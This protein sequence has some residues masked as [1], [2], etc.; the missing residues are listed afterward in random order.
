MTD[1]IETQEIETTQPIAEAAAPAAEAAPSQDLLQ[2]AETEA[3]TPAAEFIIPDA[4]KEAKCLQD[5]KSQDDLFKSFVNSQDLI[6]KKVADMSAEDLSKY[7][8][9]LGRP[10]TA[11]AYKIE[12][13]DL[14]EGTDLDWLK[15]S[16]HKA[17]ISNE[18]LNALV[19]AGAERDK[20]LLEASN[21]EIAKAQDAQIAEVKEAFGYDFEDKIKA[22]N[23]ALNYFGGEELLSL[24]KENNLGNNPIVIKAFHN[25]SKLLS[26]HKGIEGGTSAPTQSIES[27]EAQI[28]SVR[29]DPRLGNASDPKG[30]KQAQDKL[31]ELYAQKSKLV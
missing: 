5:I 20:N 16:A 10:E 24:L 18:Q 21:A 26:E 7:Y 28:A 15:V 9:K 29:N 14:Q 22:T 23:K 4:Y 12:N 2:P 27:I 8:T 19:G 30:Q 3:S 6:G 17:G 13:E 31:L 25:A 11:D 1:I